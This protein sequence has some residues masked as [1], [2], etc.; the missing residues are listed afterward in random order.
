LEWVRQ[1]GTS[2]DEQADSISVGP[3]GAVY[4][5]G[6]TGIGGRNDSFQVFTKRFDAAGNLIWTRQLMTND[7]GPTGTSADGLGDV[8]V[9]GATAASLAG[10]SDG[11]RR[12]F[13]AKYDIEGN[14]LWTTQFGTGATS[15]STDH[16]GN[17]FV[18]GYTGGD[19]SGPNGGNYDA[20]LTKV[21]PSGKLVWTRQFGSSQSDFSAGVSV[22]PAGD[23]YV[24]GTTYGDLAGPIS[25]YRQEFLGKYDSGGNL[26]WIR[27]FGSADILEYNGVA[28]GR[29]FV[30][31]ADDGGNAISKYDSSGNHLWTQHTDQ[32]FGL[33]ADN[34]GNVFT[35]GFAQGFSP[36]FSNDAD[37]SK[38][39]GSGNLLWSHL[40]GSTSLDLGYAVSTDWSRIVYVAGAT[41]GS[42]DT[43]N[44]GG[45]DAFVA[46]IS[47]VPEP[48]SLI[49]TSLGAA[50]L[51]FCC[52]RSRRRPSSG[53][54]A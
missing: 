42:L 30:Y 21:D 28:A 54:I 46:K 39:G 2:G 43:P 48:G 37:V 29:G 14:L 5:S 31:V 7:F 44:A 18:V 41:S 38:Y 34:S 23:V 10:L 32:I 40:I 45:N 15:I 22:D 20:F 25:G 51:A 6:T 19:V 8:Y 35:T 16:G 9:C 13:V 26:L 12:A 11:T 24:S 27:Q 4:V 17:V 50:A 52:L 3:S 36:T 33:A 53:A 49:L 1:F 47:D